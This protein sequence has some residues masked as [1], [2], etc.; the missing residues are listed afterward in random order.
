LLEGERIRLRAV[1]FSDGERI[2]RWINEAEALMF[3]RAPRALSKKALE[4]L[5]EK[6]TNALE[7]S[8]TNV[9]FAVET[10]DGRHI[11]LL[12]ISDVEWVHRHAVVFVLLGEPDYKWRGYEEEA[13]RLAAGYAFRLLNLNRL[14]AGV[15][16]EE[17]RMRKCLEAA[18]FKYEGRNEASFWIGDRYADRLLFRLLA[19]EVPAVGPE[20]A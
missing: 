15:I 1:E 12:Q 7:P 2:Q 17:N 10:L 19:A 11:G 3:G 9:E 14:S 13:L 18:G 16:G 8:P 5:Y 4:K 6:S 20:H